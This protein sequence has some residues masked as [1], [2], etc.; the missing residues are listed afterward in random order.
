VI[1][2]TQGE[3]NSPPGNITITGVIPLKN[4][5]FFGLGK[6][7]KRY[8]NGMDCYSSVISKIGL[9][10]ETEQIAF[11]AAELYLLFALTHWTEY[12]VR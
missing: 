10:K 11:T 6:V 9:D 3:K 1:G 12:P 2:D 4:T 7:P 8:K 5:K